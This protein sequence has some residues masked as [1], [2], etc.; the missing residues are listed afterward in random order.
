MAF[1]VQLTPDLTPV[2]PGSTTPVSVVIVNRSD[3]ADRFEMEIEGVDPEWKAVPVP[4]FGV[5]PNETHTEKIFFKPRRD[6]ESIAGNYPFVVRIRSLESGDQRTV[7]GVLQ[8]KPFH[9]LTMEISPK[10]GFVSP[11][12]KQNVFDV[13]I[14]NLGNTDHTVQLTGSDPEDAGAYEFEHERLSIAPGQQKE[15][16]LAVNPTSQ[17][18]FSGGKLIGFSVTARSI[19]APSVVASS[20]AQLEQRSLFTPTSIIIA[21]ILA[22]LLGAWILMWPKPPTISVSLDP[23]GPVTQGEEV[24]V[25]WEA[26]RA[27]KITISYG[28]Q[29]LYEGPELKGT[30]KF[31]T[32]RSGII[33]VSARAE[34]DKRE[35]VSTAQITV[36]PPEVVPAPQILYLTADPSTVNL[37]QSFILKYKFSS[38]VVKALLQP[39][40]QELDLALS[41]LE[42]KPSRVG[43]SP[44][45][46]VVMNE[47]GDRMQKS[48]SV[49]VVDRS[50]AS[51]PVFRAEPLTVKAPDTRTTLTWLVT[52]AV[53]AE[54]SFNGQT[55]PLETSGQMSFDLSAKTTFTMTAWD[56]NGKPVSRKVTVSYEKEQLPPPDDPDTTSTTGLSTTTGTEGS[57]ATTGGSTTTTTT[58]G[59]G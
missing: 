39:T 46:V 18:L 43:R 48:I 41:E 56:E 12:R 7:Q 59:G 31:A 35:V 3:V 17:P 28:E 13:A 30:R 58:T 2:E 14:V 29:V 21:L 27:S 10:K 42:I 50:K 19:E 23:P 34:K 51:I 36:A 22:T 8:I 40:G 9:H 6:S 26:E 47:K 57:T 32:D 4:V 49:A 53:K 38:S 52:G 55:L 33:S 16:E 37:G 15:I 1:S 44:Y 20:Q 11:T 54:L 24:T 45:T 5:D 25:R